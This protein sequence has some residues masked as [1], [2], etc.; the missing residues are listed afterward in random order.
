MEC[1][2]LTSHSSILFL[3]YNRNLLKVTICIWVVNHVMLHSHKNMAAAV[4]AFASL[5]DDPWFNPQIGHG[6]SLCTSGF[7]LSSLVFPN[8][9]K[10]LFCNGMLGHKGALD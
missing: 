3:S 5:R 7:P 10:A 6:A 4:S 9:V 2:P 1:F 8:S